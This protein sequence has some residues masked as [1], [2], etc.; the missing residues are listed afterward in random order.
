MRAGKLDQMITLRS[1]TYVDDGYGGQ[2]EVE[3][4]WKT[5]RAQI[6][7][8]STEEFIRGWGVSTEMLRIFRIRYLDGVQM[9]MTVIHNGDSFSIKQ[10]KEIGRRRGL[11]IRCASL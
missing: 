6:I 9:D 5:V 7:E 11:E 1:I 3:T 4:D 2:T 8:G 10:I